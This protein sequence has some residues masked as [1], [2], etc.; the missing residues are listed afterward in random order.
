[1]VKGKDADH[2]MMEC[3]EGEGMILG[4]GWE[5]GGGLLK[6]GEY[7]E[8]VKMKIVNVMV[9]RREGGEAWDGERV[10]Q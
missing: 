9:G 7:S 4:S 2:G 6:D 1:M 10:R 3:R 5:G 8:I